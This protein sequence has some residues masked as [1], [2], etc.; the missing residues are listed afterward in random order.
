MSDPTTDHAALIARIRADLPRRVVTRPT[1]NEDVVEVST[2]PSP[3]PGYAA[4]EELAARVVSLTAERDEARE[5]GNEMA[6]RAVQADT[7]LRELHAAAERVYYAPGAWTKEADTE[8]FAAH[9][10]LRAALAVSSASKAETEGSERREGAS[11]T[12]VPSGD[13]EQAD[14]DSLS[15]PPSVSASEPIC[16]CG[17]RENRHGG[18]G[19][20][21]V[22]KCSTFRPASGYPWLQINHARGLI[23]A[24]K[25]ED[26]ADTLYDLLGR[27]VQVQASEVPTVSGGSGE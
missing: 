11:V 7:A 10:A 20:G 24:G 27:G 22:C 5:H 19:C 8:R 14:R 6:E 23:L 3:S 15:S 25:S 21:E 17:H 18:D 1:A 13:G 2:E 16:E 26:A 4:L 9:E 12:T